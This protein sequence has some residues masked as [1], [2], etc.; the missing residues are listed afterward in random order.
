MKKLTE[1]NIWKNFLLFAIPLV[2][3]GLLSQAYTI[4]DTMIAGHYLG[5]AGLA[6]IAATSP[7]ITFVSSI[8]WGYMAGFGMYVARLFGEDAHE[9]I[10]RGVW[11]HFLLC[12]GV[13]IL[14]S[15]AG[16]LFVDPFLHFLRVEPEIFAAAKEYFVIYIFG[17]TAFIFGTNALFLLGSLGDSTFPFYMSLVSAV[18]NVGGNILA[19][20]VLDMGVRGIALASVFSALITGGCYLLRFRSVFKRLLPRGTRMTWSLAET[21]IAFGYSLPPILQQSAMYVAGLLLSPMINSLGS[22]ALA[23]YAVSTQIL[24]ILNSVYQNSARATSNYMAQCSGEIL[25]SA[26]KRRKLRLGVR[27]GWVQATVFLLVFLI[28]CLLAPEFFAKIFF[29]EGSAQESIALS[30]VFERVFLPFVLFNVV[31]NTFHAVFRAVKSMAFLIGSTIFSSVVR[32]GVSLPLTAS[33][34]L[35]GFWAG[36]VIA[37]IAEAILLLVVYRMNWWLPRELRNP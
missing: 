32:I 35:N 9:R 6:A 30:V 16:I 15:L 10:R 31:N 27:V 37:W 25:E 34:G 28:P 3:S 5:E 33:Y 21:R 4:I 19:V 8:L 24:A 11:I 22:T 2:L 36:M 26:E 1:G 12:A 17:F 29:S 13:S 14:I 18:L 20:T 7:A 23:S